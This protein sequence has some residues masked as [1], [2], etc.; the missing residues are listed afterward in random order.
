MS[1]FDRVTGNKT[2]EDELPEDKIKLVDE[3]FSLKSF[4]KITFAKLGVLCK[5]N[6]IILLLVSP[7]AFTLSGVAG[8][9]LGFQIAD[10]AFTPA[11]PLYGQFVGIAEYEHNSVVSALSAPY[12]LL[13]TV[14][15]DNVATIVLKCIGLLVLFT[16]GPLNVGCAYVMRNTVREKPIFVWH[17][18]FATI[19]KNF[20]QALIFGIFDCVCILAIP[21]AL[22]FYY[23]NA[24]SFAFKMLLFAMI[25]ITLLYFVMRIYIYLM[26][27]TFDLKFTKLF[28]NAF[29]LS[30]A[31]IKRSFMMILGTALIFVANAYLCII[32]RSLGVLLACIIT[33]ALI[34][35]VCYYC[36]YPVVKKYMIDPYYDENWQPTNEGDE[37]ET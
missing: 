26:I 32:I 16:W 23:S 25:L 15:I 28:K 17:D 14:N 22:L 27:V 36:A 5:L 13:S 3:K 34:M 6:L 8:S 31:G 12:T 35:F 33:V 29:I 4:F 20:K 30:S 11:S 24:N 7:L 21:Y 19:K 9:F 1:F 37:A 10:T 18:F 2:R